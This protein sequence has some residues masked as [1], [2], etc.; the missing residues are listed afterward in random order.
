MCEHTFVR[1]SA[2]D[3]E[4]QKL[5]PSSNLST[6][7]SQLLNYYVIAWKL[8]ECRNGFPAD[9]QTKVRSHNMQ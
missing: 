7:Q 3:L 9:W 8:V 6:L 5:S 2:K 1:Q 4:K